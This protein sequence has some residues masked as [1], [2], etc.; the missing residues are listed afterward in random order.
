MMDSICIK[1]I[2]GNAGDG[3]NFINWVNDVEVLKHLQEL[4][5]EGD[6]AYASGDGL[7]ARTIRFKD[8]ESLNSFLELNHIE[9][10]TMEDFE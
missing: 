5:D 9:F 4:A 8:Q 6:E 3:S 2:I 7:Q 10:T 1:M